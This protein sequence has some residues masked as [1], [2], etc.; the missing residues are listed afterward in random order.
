MEQ[1]KLVRR[2]GSQLGIS[3]SGMEYHQVLPSQNHLEEFFKTERFLKGFAQRAPQLF[4]SAP[5]QIEIEFINWGH[6]QLVYV[7][8]AAD[9]KFTVLVGQPSAEFGMVKAE[10]DNLKKLALYNSQSVVE[11][12]YYH[13]NNEREAYVAP[14]H[15]QAHCVA[16]DAVGWGTYSCAPYRFDVFSAEQRKNVNT[17]MIAL[18][19]KMFDQKEQ[20][21]I[22]ACKL[23]GGDFI[24]EKSWSQE[25]LSIEN[26]LKSMKLIAAREIVKVPFEDYLDLIRKEFKMKTHS[27]DS[28]CKSPGIVINHGARIPMSEKEIESGI[29]L[30]L[31][32]INKKESRVAQKEIASKPPTF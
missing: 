4:E 7:V 15:L 25:K 14:Y 24:L 3:S 30:G 26:T 21:G 5:N 12:I 23:G 18:L 13:C 17:C 29:R 28:R 31:S 22:A 20:S 16:S 27:G 11:P 8:S 9:Q 19:I 6:T 32:L 1:F 2:I 10:Y